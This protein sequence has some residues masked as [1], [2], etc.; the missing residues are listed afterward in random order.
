LAALARLPRAWATVKRWTAALA[1]R[2]LYVVMAALAA[3]ALL[4]V[5]TGSWPP[6]REAIGVPLL[7]LLFGVGLAATVAHG[8]DTPLARAL[9]L[10]P[11]R[12]VGRVSYGLYVIHMPLVFF[13]SRAAMMWRPDTALLTVYV[14]AYALTGALAVLSWYLWERPWLALKRYV[15]QPRRT[16]AVIDGPTTI[17]GVTP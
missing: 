3:H 5:I 13:V 1:R 6:L 4:T 8:P 2:P 17:A 12:A 7:A 9:S 10:R 15:P 14:V 16:E 11:L